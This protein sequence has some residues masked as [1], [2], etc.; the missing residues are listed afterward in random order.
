MKYYR[1]IYLLA[2]VCFTVYAKADDCYRM[3]RVNTPIRYL[4]DSRTITTNTAYQPFVNGKP[5]SGLA[6]TGIVRKMSPDYFVRVLL[7]D[8]EGK[9][10]L[11]METYEELNCNEVFRLEDYSEET[12]LLAN[13]VPDSLKI[14]LKEATLQVDCLSI[15]EAFQKCPFDIEARQREIKNRQVRTAIDRINAYNKSNG[16]I[17]V[18]GKT[19]LANYSYE[20]RKGALGFADDVCIGGLEYYV[21]GYFVFGHNQ[22]QIRNSGTDDPFVDSFDWRNRH[23]KNWITPVRHQGWTEYCVA[24]AVLGCA[25]ALA[26]LYYNNTN[27]DLDMSEQELASCADSI[28]HKWNVSLNEN[29]VLKYLNEHGVYDE[30]AYPFAYPL[31]S[32]HYGDTIVCMTDDISPNV[33]LK[34]GA[35]HYGIQYMSQLKAALISKGPLVSGWLPNTSNGHAMALVGYGKIHAGDSVY[36]YNPNTGDKTPHFPVTSQYVGSTYWIFKNSYGPNSAFNGYY[37]LI[38]DDIIENNGDFIFP[39]MLIPAMLDVPV[40][41]KKYIGNEV[42]DFSED[43]VIVEDADG[44]G[45][46]NWGIG[47]KPAGCPSW[48][49][50]T[51]D[52]DDFDNTKAAMDSYGH[53]QSIPQR[54]PWTLTSNANIAN[55]QELYGSIIIPYGQTLTISGSV[56]CLGNT[57]IKVEA[58]GQLI[59]DGGVLANASINMEASSSLVI[60]NGGTIYMRTGQDFYAPVGSVVNITSGEICGPYIKKSAKWLR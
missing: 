56:I 26:K 39:S 32:Y 57:C 52:G 19:E 44:D 40:G 8:K 10:Y 24:F 5:I 35:Y 33:W 34:T 3:S 36:T 29:K 6:V 55:N 45:F 60:D 4:K 27:I 14:F 22:I 7:K 50:D 38:F 1:M 58:G 49:P 2:F 15:A 13:V 59:V 41:Y 17:W 9:E 25:E 42:V 16:R 12:Q 46:Y 31:D 28:P 43:D 21:G 11:V 23:G 30:V 51:E 18:A 53:L 37:Y 54:E 20:V 47:E 48:V